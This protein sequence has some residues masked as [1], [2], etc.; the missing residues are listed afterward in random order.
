MSYSEEK[1]FELKLVR[2]MLKLKIRDLSEG[3]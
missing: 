3:I 1:E 2:K